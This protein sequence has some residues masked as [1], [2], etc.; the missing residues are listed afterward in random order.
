M[1]PLFSFNN[2]SWVLGYFKNDLSLNM[3]AFYTET[4]K[5]VSNIIQYKIPF[6][7]TFYVS[8]F[9]LF[10]KKNKIIDL[11]DY[12]FDINKLISIFENGRTEDEYS[13]LIDYGLPLT[14][15]TKIADNKISL[16]DLKRQ[17]FDQSKFDD[18]EKMIISETVYLM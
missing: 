18:Y 12:T 6:Y 15:V 16:D 5:I 7:L 3:N 10:I 14:T 4:F 1:A 8:I 17:K 2:A 9:K 11:D 13:K